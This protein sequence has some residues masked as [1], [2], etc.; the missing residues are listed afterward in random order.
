MCVGTLD[1]G[2]VGACVSHD[3][4]VDVALV[5]KPGSN[6][7]SNTQPLYLSSDLIK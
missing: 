1:V 4:I 3:P 6:K 7:L 5:Y 2:D